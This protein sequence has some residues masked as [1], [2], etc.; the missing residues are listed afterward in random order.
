M[1]TAIEQKAAE[2]RAAV[3][4]LEALKARIPDSVLQNP[5]LLRYRSDFFALLQNVIGGRSDI[6]VVGDRFVFQAE[7]LF[8]PGSD[9]IGK[10][11]KDVLDAFIKALNDVTARI[12][13]TINWVLIVDG[14]T[15]RIPIHN[16]TFDSNWELS[17]FRAVSVVKYLIS[18]GVPPEHLAAAGFAEHFPLTK[19]PTKMAKNRRIEFRLDQ[20]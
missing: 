19:E 2:L 15:D 14:H 17:A 20:R 12:P 1:E 11:G 8:Q 9:K 10:Q 3:E 18:K 16:D 4:A 6:R 5:E 13:K 7:V